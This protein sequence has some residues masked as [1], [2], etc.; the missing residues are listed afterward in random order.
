MGHRGLGFNSSIVAQKAKLAAS[1]FRFG[2]GSLD[3]QDPESAQL[4]P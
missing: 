4:F 3:S 2:S 1:R